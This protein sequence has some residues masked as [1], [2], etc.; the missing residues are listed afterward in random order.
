MPYTPYLSL[1]V[2]YTTICQP[3]EASY[4]PRLYLFV[5]HLAECTT[6]RNARK[7]DGTGRYAERDAYF[8]AGSDVALALGFYPNEAIE[9]IIYNNNPRMRKQARP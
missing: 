4:L 9:N 7:E 2:L 3:N 6:G 1:F 5:F 8:N